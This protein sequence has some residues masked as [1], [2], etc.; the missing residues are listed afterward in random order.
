AAL[1]SLKRLMKR[2]C[3]LPGLAAA[4]CRWLIQNNSGRLKDLCCGLGLSAVHDN[5][6]LQGRRATN[7]RDH[8]SEYGSAL[9]YG[10]YVAGSKADLECGAIGQL[11]AARGGHTVAARDQDA[12]ESDYWHGDKGQFNPFLCRS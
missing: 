2:P 1:R 11:A 5:H 9:G 10:P 7:T 6:R 8:S 3:D 4:S 12:I